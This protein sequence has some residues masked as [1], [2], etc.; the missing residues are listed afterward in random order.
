MTKT[1]LRVTGGLC[2]TRGRPLERYFRDPL[3]GLF[4]PPPEDDRKRA[5]W[6]V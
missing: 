4:Q 6:D 1:A 2:M 5:A 3:G